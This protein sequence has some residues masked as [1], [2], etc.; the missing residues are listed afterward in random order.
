MPAKPTRRT[1]A[2]QWELLKLI[3]SCGAGASATELALALQQAGFEVSKRQVER[4]L[5]ELREA[6]Q[7]ECNE[8][9]IP[10]GWRWPTGAG[11]EFPGLT[12]AEALSL[13]LL[14][15]TLGALLPAPWLTVLG[16]RLASAEHKLASLKADLGDSAAWP[17]KVRVVQPS[18]PL[19]AP[20]INAEVL[21]TVQECLLASEQVEVD[22]VSGPGSAPKTL[23]LNPL[24]QV[25]R[26]PVSYLVAT[27][28]DYPDVRLY[29]LHRIT[30]A[31]RLYV[32]L[33][34]PPGFNVDDY[35]ADGALQFGSHGLIQLRAKVSAELAHHLGET[36][37]SADQGIEG[38]VLSATVPDTW[39]LSWWLLSQG[40][41]IEV[42]E[43]ASL[44]QR[45]H[46]SLEQA[47]AA[48]QLVP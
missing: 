37:L 4:D 7:L 3:P 10:Y 44:R 48:Y 1:L 6:F 13:C 31:R 12:A 15:Q 19:L 39:Q 26:G 22:Y 14:K 38:G 16:P 20:D 33:H 8:K 25:N 23:T 21:E 27:A 11:I 40:P 45:I 24:A 46:Q 2:R 35:L 18:L 32:E 29:A 43:P 41:Q 5:W 9:S 34:R 42:L 30:V 17:H 36:A 28:W 47:L